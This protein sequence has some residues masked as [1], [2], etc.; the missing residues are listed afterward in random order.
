MK[1][2]IFYLILIVNSVKAQT[3]FGP[4]GAEASAMGGANIAASNSFSVQNNVAGMVWS[5]KAEISIYNEMKYRLSNLSLSNINILIPFKHFHLGASIN[6]F[7]YNLYNQQ[8]FNVAIAR[9]LNSQFSLGISMALFGVNISENSQAY[10]FLGDIGIQYIPT[11]KWHFGLSL[12]NPTQSKLSENNNLKIPTY[13]RM[14]VSYNVSDKLLCNAE[15]EKSLGLPEIYRTGFA[16]KIHPSFILRA[17][18]SSNPFLLTF[19]VGV[20]W[21][22]L[23]VDMATSYHQVLGITPHLSLIYVFAD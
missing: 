9:K 14:G 5:N 10:A 11:K 13:A 4:L 1:Q 20:K 21:S 3:V 16:Y 18:G 12:F 15:F 23:K 8:K 6:Y 7:G 22:K 17:G 2:L 19:G